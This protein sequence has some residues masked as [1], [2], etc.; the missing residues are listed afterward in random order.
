MHQ[1]Q[2]P[3]GRPVKSYFGKAAE[4]KRSPGVPAPSGLPSQDGRCKGRKEDGSRCKAS[5][6]R[7]TRYCIGH[8]KQRG[9]A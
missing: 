8:L 4:A 1:N 6:A 2:G 7:G 9:E 3:T 5:P